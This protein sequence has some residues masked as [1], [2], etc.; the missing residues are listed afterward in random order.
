MCACTAG[1]YRRGTLSW[2]ACSFIASNKQACSL[3]QRETLP[4]LQR[5]LAADTTLRIVLVK[6]SQGFA[7]L[8]HTARY[9]GAQDT[10]GGVAVNTYK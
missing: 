7:F 8:G 9:L 3:S 4:H 1:C 2:E 5:L 6:I 10:H